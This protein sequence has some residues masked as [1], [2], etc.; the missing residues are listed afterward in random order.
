[1]KIKNVEINGF[2]AMAPMAGVA[3]LAVRTVSREHGAC[4]AVGEMTSAKGISMGS[5]KSAELLA[6][7]AA[8]PFA[9]QLFGADAACMKLAAAEAA[10]R[11]PDIIDINMGCPAPK[12]TGGLAGSALLKNLK[13]AAEVARAA[14]EGAGD[15]PVTVKIRKGYDEGDDVAV[16]AA[17]LLEEQGVAAITVH[18][19]TR[20][21]MYSPPVDTG[22]IARVKAAVKIPVIGNGD[23]FTAEDAKRMF[24]TTGCDLVMVGRGALGN[25]WL[26][27][28][29]NAVMRGEPLPKRPTLK[30]R[31]DVMRREIT[32]LTEDKGEYIGF[33]EARKHVSWYMT[34]LR[35]AARLR[36]LCG[37]INGWADIEAICQAALEENGENPPEDMS[38]AAK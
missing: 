28:E 19:R 34:G 31:L 33:K 27:D 35:G 38:G 4:Y 29:I 30:E 24:E 17:K 36:R 10:K 20:S 6:V 3:D 18:G 2:A 11:R 26:F 32:L 21:Q 9:V 14:V 37:E 5:K 16:E 15:I 12:I 25:P 22:C 23:I 1:M 7:D 8:R 13:L